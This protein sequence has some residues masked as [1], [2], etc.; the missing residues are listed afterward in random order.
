[1]QETLPCKPQQKFITI[2]TTLELLRYAYNLH[3]FGCT[4]LEECNIW[5]LGTGSLIGYEKYNIMMQSYK[6]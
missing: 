2:K 1:M 5:Y 4:L 6:W 3:L